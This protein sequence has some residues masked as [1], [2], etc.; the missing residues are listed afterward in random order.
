MTALIVQRKR[1]VFELQ[2]IQACQEIEQRVL[3]TDLVETAAEL[4]LYENR[5]TANVH[6]Q[7]SGMVDKTLGKQEEFLFP[8]GAAF[9]AAAVLAVVK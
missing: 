4:L 3:I 2:E 5:P 9:D 7:E 1:V 6:I 8:C